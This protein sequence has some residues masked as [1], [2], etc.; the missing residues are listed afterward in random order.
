MYD[1]LRSHSNASPNS[2]R[3]LVFWPDGNPDPDGKLYAQPESDLQIGTCSAKEYCITFVR[4]LIL[5][6][7]ITRM[8]V[9]WWCD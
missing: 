9:V 6:C 7:K 1:T 8:Q 5:T 2:V 4:W 3:M